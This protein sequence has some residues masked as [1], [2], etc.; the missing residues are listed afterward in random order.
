LVKPASV[1]DVAATPVVRELRADD[2][3]AG[4]GDQPLRNRHGIVIEHDVVD[5][6]AAQNR[7][8]ERIEV[9]AG[10]AEIVP[11]TVPPV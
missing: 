10:D 1:V 2:V 6:A 4:F 3:A 7:V 5:F 8:A 11:C 9:D